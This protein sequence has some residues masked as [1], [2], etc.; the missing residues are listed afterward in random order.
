MEETGQ[1]I[2]I[3]QNTYLNNLAEQDHRA[4]KRIVSANSRI[5]CS[6]KI[7]ATEPSYPQVPFYRL[8]RLYQLL[9]GHSV[10]YLA[11]PYTLFGIT[12][13]QEVIRLLQD[14]G[15][16]NASAGVRRMQGQ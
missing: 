4:V 13:G 11:S 7:N 14:N 9:Q 12:K 1:E 3:R 6:G 5:M 10:A 8:R 2:E 15:G 16:R